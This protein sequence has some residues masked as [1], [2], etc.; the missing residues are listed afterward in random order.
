VT[1]G[2]GRWN[3]T[4][5]SEFPLER[6]GYRANG[7]LASTLDGLT[8]PMHNH[9]DNYIRLRKVL[10]AAEWKVGAADAVERIFLPHVDEKALAGLKF[11]VALP[12]RL[13]TAAPAARIAD[14][15]GTATVLTEP[16]YFAI[17]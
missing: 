11:S 17:E 9:E 12:E 7:T 10:R 4:G 6:A 15:D 5:P 8:D 3:Q 1:A 13:A 14:L 16:T 2:P